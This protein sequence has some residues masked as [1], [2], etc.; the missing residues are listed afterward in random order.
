MDA[1]EQLLQRVAALEAE[2][3]PLRQALSIYAGFGAAWAGALRG[4][5]EALRA[6]PGVIRA[7]EA[8]LGSEAAVISDSC[9]NLAY[10]TAFGDAAGLIVNILKQPLAAANAANGAEAVQASRSERGLH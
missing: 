3:Q 6:D 2:L 8:H 7:V 4:L 1:T 5:T 10:V 9:H